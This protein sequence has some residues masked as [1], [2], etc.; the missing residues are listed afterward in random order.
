MRLKSSIEKLV[1]DPNGKPFLYNPTNEQ[2]D[3]PN[4][5]FL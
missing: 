1:E 2:R 4:G 5:Y 3:Y